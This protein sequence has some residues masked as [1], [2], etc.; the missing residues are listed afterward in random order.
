[1][2]RGRPIKLFFVLFSRP[3][4]E[5]LDYNHFTDEEKAKQFLS[6]YFFDYLNELPREWFENAGFVD[7]L[8]PNKNMVLHPDV[9]YELELLMDMVEE[10]INELGEQQDIDYDFRE[11]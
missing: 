9:N 8:T 11:L 5:I 10:R 4:K 6:N 3:S 2:K 7:S 1:M